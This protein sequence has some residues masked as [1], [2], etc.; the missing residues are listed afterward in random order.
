MEFC[1]IIH[2]YINLKAEALPAENKIFIKL[3]NA[4]SSVVKFLNF[5]TFMDFF[6]L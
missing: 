6:V 4:L 5:R 2:R 1:L 3:I